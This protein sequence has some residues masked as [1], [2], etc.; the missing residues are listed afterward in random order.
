MFKIIRNNCCGLDVHKT[1]IYACIGITDNHS[2]TEYYE[3]RFSS[4]PKGLRRLADWLQ[5]YSCNEVCMESSGKYWIPVFNALE[6]TCQVTLAHPK[7]T[8]PQKG[9]KTDRKDARWI[10]DLFM[11]GMIK[12]SFIPPPAIRHL[13]ELIRY[14]M[15][16]T[17]MLTSEKNRAHNCLTVS[18]L[19][20]DD[21]F[22]DIFGKSA[23]SITEYILSHP[24]EHFDVTPFID[25]RCKT[26]IDV[27]QDAVDGAISP[28]QAV[29]LRECLKHIDELTAHRN[30]IEKEILALVKPFSTQL[31]LI[32]T[33]PGLNKDP[34]TAITILSEIGSDMS[35]FPT[36]KNLVSWAGCC[37]RNDKSAKHVKSTRIAAAGTYLKPILVQVA[38]G[39]VKSRKHPEFTER[40]RRIKSHR[41]HKKA[42]IALC[43]MLLTAIWNI[44]STG[45]FYNPSG[46]FLQSPRPVDEKKV[47]TQK[48][49]LEL[50]RLRGYLIAED[51]PTQ[52][53]PA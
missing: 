45:E 44:L 30:N 4:F 27:I 13:R 35:V 23:R 19:K 15:K 31:D 10:C 52:A 53:S 3:E 17:N 21:V 18:S 38:N 43:K 5:Q 34:I 7:Y 20:L 6:K 32:R 36:A 24:G 33:V 9:N 49:A 41:G 11:C 2:R 28:E 22:S 46:Y 12:P 40:Y 26:P 47:L 16:L 48:Q 1:W 8:K 29:K 25:K 42:M 14:R 51:E 37:P 39:L 50:L